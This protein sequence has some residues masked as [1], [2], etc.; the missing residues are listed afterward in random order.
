MSVIVRQL[1]PPNILARL[2]QAAE[3]GDRVCIEV[4]HDGVKKYLTSNSLFS[5]GEDGPYTTDPVLALNWAV[6]D[7]DFTEMWYCLHTL[8]IKDV[9][10]GRSSPCSDVPG[11]IVTFKIV[12]TESQRLA[13]YGEYKQ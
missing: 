2:N 13:D 4:V 10:G 7:P 8:Y 1:P 3:R 6:K 11:Q 5:G 12:A 9:G